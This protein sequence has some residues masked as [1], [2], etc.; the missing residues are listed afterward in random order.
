MKRITP[1]QIR[2]ALFLPICSSIGLS[3]SYES[4]KKTIHQA[5]EEYKRN[6]LE[7][8]L[9]ISL[10][11]LGTIMTLIFDLSIWIIGHKQVPIKTRN[12]YSK[13]MAAISQ[14]QHVASKTSSSNQ[15]INLNLHLGPSTS[16][17]NP[18]PTQMMHIQIWTQI[19]SPSKCISF[20]K[21]VCLLALYCP[22]CFIGRRFCPKCNVLL[23]LHL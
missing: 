1:C 5:L 7:P 14:T 6:L 3:Q 18:I 23:S 21:I 22:L 10:R 15:Q 20:D 4:T 12:Q 19:M 8:N 2:M 9:L 13:Q 17:I 16:P 11:I